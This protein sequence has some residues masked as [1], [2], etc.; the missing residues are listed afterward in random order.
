M[1]KNNILRI[2]GIVS[3][4]PGPDGSLV[5]ETSNTLAPEIGN[6]Y[7]TRI[8][9]SLRDS[10]L[11]GEEAVVIEVDG[12]EYPVILCTGEPLQVGR[13]RRRQFLKLLFEFD[14]GDVGGRFRV[15]SDV[16]PLCLRVVAATAAG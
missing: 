3:A 9:I 14:S 15:C 7:L 2:S 1:C 8:C 12:V 6:I 11:T 13:L 10:D 5:L 16:C 4:T